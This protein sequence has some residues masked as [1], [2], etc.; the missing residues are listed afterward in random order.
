MRTRWTWLRRWPAAIAFLLAGLVFLSPAG[1]ASE[2][3][4]SFA[5]SWL[6]AALDAQYE[7]GSDLAFKDAPL[8]GT[9]NSFNSVAE[10]GP[11][12]PQLKSNQ[13][14]TLTEQL[15]FG[16]RELELDLHREPNGDG[17]DDRPVVCH[18]LADFGCVAVRD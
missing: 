16:V 1:A 5:G 17:S 7:L 12:L 18:A 15:D 2:D 14:A 10:M 3:E 8:I 13:D 9:H 4:G 6:E 11:G